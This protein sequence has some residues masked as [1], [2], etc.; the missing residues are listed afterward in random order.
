M[1]KSKLIKSILEKWSNDESI[2]SATQFLT[3]SDKKILATLAADEF[4]NINTIEKF[5]KIKSALNIEIDAAKWEDSRIGEMF[6]TNQIAAQEASKYIQRYF[7]DSIPPQP[8]DTFSIPEYIMYAIILTGLKA[9]ITK[10]KYRSPEKLA[11][12][13]LGYLSFRL[14][15]DNLEFKIGRKKKQDK[16]K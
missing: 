4:I 15:V 2:K 8:K 10:Y 12:F 14:P 1:I 5:D 9:A 7:K 16:P 11:L 6:T 13:I 3:E